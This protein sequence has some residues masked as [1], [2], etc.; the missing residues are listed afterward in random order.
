LW[1][2]RRLL[3]KDAVALLVVVVTRESAK[4]TSEVLSQKEELKG[5]DVA[6]VGAL[7]MDCLPCAC[8]FVGEDGN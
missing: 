7:D 4:D 5:K 2:L 3:G 6:N 8:G 1:T